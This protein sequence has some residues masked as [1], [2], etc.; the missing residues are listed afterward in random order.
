MNIII[1]EDYIQVLNSLTGWQQKKL[2]VALENYIKTKKTPNLNKKVL[3]VFMLL[4]KEID[5]QEKIAQKRANA[6]KKGAKNRWNEEEQ[7]KN[8]RKNSKNN[9]KM[10]KHGKKNIANGKCYKADGKCHN[11]NFDKMANAITQKTP[12]T[13][14]IDEILA[15]LE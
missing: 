1:R 10:A 8:N 14:R 7:E 11:A 2:F 9:V 4:S 5:V 12:I 6:G 13:A 15:G 3:S